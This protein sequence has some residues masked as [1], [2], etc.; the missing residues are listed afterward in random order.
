MRRNGSRSPADIFTLYMRVDDLRKVLFKK[1]EAQAKEREERTG[2][3]RKNS[4]PESDRAYNE[5]D[6]LLRAIDARREIAFD[7]FLFALGIR[8]VGEI[9]SK[10]LAKHFKDVPLFIK[11]VESAAKDRP[12]AEWIELGDIQKIGPVTRERLLQ[13]GLSLKTVQTDFFTSDSG[14]AVKLSN[15]QWKNLLSHY[16]SEAG[17]HQ[18]LWAA[19]L[20]QPK[21][22]YARLAND[23]DIGPV[24][25]DALINFFTEPHNKKFVEA[26][27]K[28][29]TVKPVEKAEADSPISGKTRVFT[30]SLEKM[31][32]DE[33]KAVADRLAQKCRTPFL[34]KTDLVIAGPGAGSKLTEAMKHGVK[35]ISE[36][37]WLK[38]IGR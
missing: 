6:N 29:L 31:A 15:T 5:I 2:K 8:H 32:R 34:K 33:A 25:T 1:R 37:E 20:Q 16:K 24:A 17:L 21:E 23:S 3:A 4:A 38:L 35:V 18:A 27:L 14:R 19:R 11:A 30:G 36:D 13:D 26:L 12:G 9:T 28:Q 10:A 7:R 22:G